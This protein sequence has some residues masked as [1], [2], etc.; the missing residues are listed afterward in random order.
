MFEFS[1]RKDMR[2]INNNGKMRFL[3]YLL[4]YLLTLIVVELGSSVEQ[5]RV[6]TTPNV[7][8]S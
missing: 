5:G 8:E 3:A 2:K 6:V 4:T 1:V 7:I